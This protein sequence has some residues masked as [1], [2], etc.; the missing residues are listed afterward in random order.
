M[1]RQPS[2]M[3]DSKLPTPPSPV[4]PSP[5]LQLTRHGRQLG[6]N[7]RP[8]H[9]HAPAWPATKHRTSGRWFL[10]T[11][12]PGVP[13][14]LATTPSAAAAFGLPF[15]KRLQ[16]SRGHDFS[17][18]SNPSS[19]GCKTCLRLRW[20]GAKGWVAGDAQPSARRHADT[21]S[22]VSAHFYTSY[23]T[24]SAAGTIEHP[25]LRK[26]E[27]RRDARIVRTSGLNTANDG[28]SQVSPRLITA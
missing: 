8:H 24:G 14:G 11:S 13:D 20:L 4:R 6:S 23:S 22:V 10:P 25:L 26:L 3:P 12:R 19:R 28:P 5:S 16:R 17:A 7:V 18:P 1:E 2:K 9:R 27:W 21:R 15:R